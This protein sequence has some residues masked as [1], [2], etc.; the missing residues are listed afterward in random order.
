MELSAP[1]TKSMM[2]VKFLTNYFLKNSLLLIKLTNS[3]K[4]ATLG[5]R[6]LLRL[7]GRLVVTRN[8]VLS[9]AHRFFSVRLDVK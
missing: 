3:L 6:L 8:I 9:I 1:S 2:S 5:E 4:R 7:H